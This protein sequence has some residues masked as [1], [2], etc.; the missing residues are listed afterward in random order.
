MMMNWMAKTLLVLGGLACVAWS[1]PA[2][3]L[4]W[5]NYNTCWADFDVGG[6]WLCML[7]N[8]ACPTPAQLYCKTTVDAN[9][10]PAYSTSAP[11]AKAIA[12]DDSGYVWLIGND[13][14]IY[15]EAGGSAWPQFSPAIPTNCVRK[16]AIAGVAGSNPRILALSCNGAVYR[17]LDGQWGVQ[18]NSGGLDV[19]VTAVGASG[20]TLTY[21]YQ[22]DTVSF[23][24]SGLGGGGIMAHR[25]AVA[26]EFF[27][28]GSVVHKT[29]RMAGYTGF[30]NDLILCHN[31]T[32]QFGT[33]QFY[34]FSSSRFLIGDPAGCDHLRI[35]NKDVDYASSPYVLKV[36]AGNRGPGND[37]IW[38]LTNI[39]RVI[40]L[41]D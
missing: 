40:A 37:R 22:S 6:G 19:S 28:G 30:F 3:A 25:S 18:R 35:L 15:Y 31:P 11:A 21:L 38:A 23:A 7:R 36:A 24:F 1:K 16:L 8:Q 2:S 39:G 12:L 32:S 14:K 9:L 20:A 17:Y 34:S 4:N 41:D 13:N 27:T 5:A 29:S 26:T 33:G 10:P